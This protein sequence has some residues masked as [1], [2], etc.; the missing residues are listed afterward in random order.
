M[1]GRTRLIA[2][3]GMVAES[4]FCGFHIPAKQAV[5]ASVSAFCCLE[6][7]LVL[8][9]S[10]K[11]GSAHEFC[12]GE[13][14]RIPLY[15]LGRG[16]PDPRPDRLTPW[17]AALRARWSKGGRSS[18][19]QGHRRANCRRRRPRRWFRRRRTSRRRRRPL[20]PPEFLVTAPAPPAPAIQSTQVAPPAAPVIAPQAPVAAAPVVRQAGRR[21]RQD[22]FARRRRSRKSGRQLHRRRWLPGDCHREIRQGGQRAVQRHAC[23]H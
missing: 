8:P 14:G 16:H 7:C 5:H 2:A 10:W 18:R 20:P 11:K 21:D 15:G 19:R 22:G 6:R 13:A 9:R 17:P 4:R 12:A 3:R 23:W 1:D